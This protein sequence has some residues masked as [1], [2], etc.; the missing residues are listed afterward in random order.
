MTDLYNTYLNSVEEKI[1]N[2]S[3]DNLMLDTFCKKIFGKS[4]KGV[5]SA[6]NI[7]KLTKTKNKCIYNLDK[8]GG[9]GTHWC[10]LW[11]DP[12]TGICYSYDSFARNLKKDRSFRNMDKGRRLI[13]KQSGDRVPEQ[14]DAEENCGARSVSWLCCCDAVEKDKLKIDK[15]LKI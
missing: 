3:T 11:K 15:L 12:K 13:M 4:F 2:G 6:D 9:S 14:A 5:Y 7:P 10:S 8:S 1:G